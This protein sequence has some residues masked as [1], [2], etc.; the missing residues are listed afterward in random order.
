[1]KDLVVYY[2]TSDAGYP[3]DKPSDVNN[4]SCLYNFLKEFPF[5]SVNII[6]MADNV[7]DETKE[8]LEKES[9]GIDI[10][11][12]SIGSS[13]GTFSNVFMDSLNLD[14]DTIVYFVENDYIHAPNAMNALFDGFDLGSHYVTLY[15]HPDKY[16]R[17]Y[18]FGENTRVMKGNIC[19]WKMT[20]STTMTFAAKVSTLNEDKDIWTKHTSGTYP[21]D[22]DA[23]TELRGKGRILVSPI[24][25]Y[26]THGETAWLSP[27]RNWEMI[28]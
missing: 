24:P 4:F 28:I 10:H 25:G 6:V 12:T 2:R 1:M 14:D 22:H 13:A 3:K 9:S 20:I 17:S 16:I 21:T 7:S 19:H 18:N 11:Y 23:F 8:K 27:F 26:S 15:D 5:K